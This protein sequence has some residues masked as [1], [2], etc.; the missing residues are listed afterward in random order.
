[1]AREKGILILSL[2]GDSR[3]GPHTACLG[4]LQAVDNTAFTNI[5][6]TWSHVIVT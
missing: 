2:L 5:W 3:S 4:P 1:M 6:E